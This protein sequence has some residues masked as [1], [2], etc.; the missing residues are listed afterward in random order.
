MRDVLRNGTNRVKG[1]GRGR[2]LLTGQ[3]ERSTRAAQPRSAAKRRV[4]FFFFCFTDTDPAASPPHH[5]H[6]IFVCFSPRRD[7]R[8]PPH[9]HPPSLSLSTLQPSQP[10]VR[11]SPSTSARP[12]RRE[13]ER[14]RGGRTPKNAPHLVWGESAPFS[15]SVARFRT[16]P[17]AFTPHLPT[18]HRPGLGRG[19]NGLISGR[20]RMP[21]H[22]LQPGFL[23]ARRLDSPV[24]G[25]RKKRAARRF[26]G[27]GLL[28]PPFVTLAVPRPCWRPYAWRGRPPYRPSSGSGRAGRRSGRAGGA[29]R[30][31]HEAAPP[32]LAPPLFPLLSSHSTHHTPHFPTPAGIQVGNSCWELYCLEHG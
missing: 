10:C 15:R 20:D 9:H 21:S 5:P 24:G 6:S 14:Q 32:F 17:A 23:S 18:H 2:G 22:P 12:V 27:R 25:E 13:A 26:A 31:A 29:R 3:R 1:K 11:S 19:L 7:A 16:R 4:N 8:G 30:S 28:P